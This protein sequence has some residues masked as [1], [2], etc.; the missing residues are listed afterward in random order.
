MNYPPKPPENQYLDHL[1]GDLQGLTQFVVWKL[2]PRNEGGKLSK[3]PYDARTGRRASST[4][5]QTWA[6][7]DIALN[8]FSTGDYD[9]IG[10]VFANGYSGVDLD[11]CRD[12]VS[13]EIASW[14]L[15]I[16]RMLDSYTEISPSGTGLHVLLKAK[17]DDKGARRGPVEL[18]D[19][20][21]YFTLT[22]L[23]LKGT[24][25]TINDRQ[26]V[27]SELHKAIR[28]IQTGNQGRSITPKSKPVALLLNDEEIL[29]RARKAKNGAKFERLWK[30]NTAEYDDDESRADSALVAMLCFYTPDDSQVERLWKQSGLYRN[31]LERADYVQLTIRNARSRQTQSY[32]PKSQPARIEQLP[33]DISGMEEIEGKERLE[34]YG[35]PVSDD[36]G[37]E[38]YLRQCARNA[39]LILRC[40]TIF[41]RLLGFQENHS[42]FLNAITA[43]GK[44]R[45]GTF[46]ASQEWLRKYYL[47]NGKA[48][49]K[50]T[51]KRH[52]KRLLIEQKKIGVALI[53]YT[54]GNRYY[55]HQ[56]G[57]E[58]RLASK[59]QNHLLRLS[60]K[61]V[62]KAI[63]L[64][65]E[66]E[67][68][69]AFLEQACEMV[70]NEENLPRPQEPHF[71]SR[72]GKKKPALQVIMQKLSHTYGEWLDQMLAEGRSETQ[73]LEEFEKLQTEQAIRLKEVCAARQQ[74]TNFN[75]SMGVKMNPI[76][77]RENNGEGTVNVGEVVGDCPHCSQPLLVLTRPGN[78]KVRVQCPSNPELF[79]VLRNEDRERCRDCDQ[80]LP[81]IAGRCAECIQRLM[82]ASDKPCTN[83]GSGRFWR[84][85]ATKER[86]AGFAWYC[87]YCIEPSDEFVIFELQNVEEPCQQ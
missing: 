14:A 81:V 73:I 1:P 52:R 24:P 16:V 13:G 5:P 18:Y 39:S 48:S 71:G 47:E 4:N 87:A 26:D 79:K 31:K 70:I 69:Q 29:G 64:K 66:G 85:R 50:P 35:L 67:S 25:T 53:T 65:G 32:N 27:V 68:F 82:L 19:T 58:V 77:N 55:D 46:I 54:P 75:F 43:I 76:E 6:A 15:D 33:E 80:H 30:G 56:A 72:G 11:K 41:L 60:L 78:D 23:H 37:I 20:G 17:L 57:K 84:Y 21:R 36:P 83:C 22:G 8:A 86:S 28:E 40:Y 44:D 38:K 42:C 9:G 2:E 12:P 51:I 49:S 10:F 45:L 62:S 63:E 3:I 59:Y 61:A 74:A 34:E 7:F